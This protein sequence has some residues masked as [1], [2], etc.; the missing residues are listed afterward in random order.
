LPVYKRNDGFKTIKFSDG[1]LGYFSSSKSACPITKF[2]A[3][4]QALKLN[5]WSNPLVKLLDATDLLSTRL[6]IS[7]SSPLKLSIF[8]E[9]KTDDKV[10]GGSLEIQATVCGNEFIHKNKSPNALYVKQ[11]G[12]T[13]EF[14]HAVYSTYFSS[15]F[16]SIDSD[17]LCTHIKKYS[18][19]EG[20]SCTGA[21]SLI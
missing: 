19:Y 18:V 3:Y 14:S 7:T 21:S 9:A 20:N 1:L 2:I 16:N 10:S 4:S 15:I 11:I 17:S 8:L 13:L 5:I 6:E 12:E